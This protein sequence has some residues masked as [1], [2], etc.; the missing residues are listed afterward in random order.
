MTL[1]LAEIT[2]FWSEFS[3]AEATL[4]S[5]PLHER[6]EESNALIE[7]HLG[8][9]SLEIAGGEG[10]AVVDLV[11]TAHGSIENF[12]LLLQVV[13]A[14]PALRRHRVRAFRE[15]TMQPDFP[16]G[17][18]G[19]ELATSDVWVACGQDGGQIAL[20]I[21]F[22]REIPYDY[23]DHAHNMAFIM[24]DHVLGEYD[25][26]VKVGPVDFVDEAQDPAAQWIPLSQLPPAFDRYWKATLGRT[27]T[28]PTGE[29]EW[30]VLTHTF[31]SEAERA[32]S[33]P[34]EDTAIVLVNCS[35]N[36]VAM[37]ADLAHA[38]SLELDV[39]DRDGMVAAQD[40]QDHAATL[41]ELPQLGILA[42]T[43]T[44]AGRRKAVYYVGDEHLARQALAPLLLR[45][46]AESFA[47][48]T[49]F[50][51]AWSAYF[52]FAGR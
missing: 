1:P 28:F 45:R 3:A 24:L 30:S 26:A 6:V 19:F 44:L 46:D 33:A 31:G 40:L 17:M 37:R 2:A 36:P 29:H 8:G 16:I 47:L 12:P 49:A 35:A 43:L 38:L 50:D 10:D 27:G 41:L 25:F 9:L 5:H 18:E 21:R 34:S 22:A 23:L 48:S 7:R 20:E 15:R 14:A 39:H 13:A 42:Y 51:P 11:V 32:E 52:E 4:A